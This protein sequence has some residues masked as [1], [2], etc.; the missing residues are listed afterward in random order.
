M[1]GRTHIFLAEDET[2]A[3]RA[4]GSPNAVVANVF[5]VAQFDWGFANE[6]QWT[7][8]IGS[9]AGGPSAWAIKPV[10]Q[11]AV[12]HTTGQRNTKPRWYDVPAPHAAA[13]MYEGEDFINLTQA[14][15]TPLQQARSLRAF[16]KWMRIKLEPTF[17]GGTDPRLLCSLIA[18]TK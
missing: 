6:C 2:M 4:V 15:A 8:S 16:G 1:P 11:R 14:M 7:F 5:P 18:E 3:L 17:T 9:V 10:L 12:I 13:V